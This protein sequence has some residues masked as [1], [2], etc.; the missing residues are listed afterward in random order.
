VE[1]KH[2]Q[3]E[4]RQYFEGVTRGDDKKSMNF[5]GETKEKFMEDWDKAMNA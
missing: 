1:T 5:M 2:L 4:P 3:P